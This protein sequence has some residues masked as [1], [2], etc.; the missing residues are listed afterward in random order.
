MEY[1]IRA[2]NKWLDIED[3]LLVLEVGDKK[4][5]EEIAKRHK[6]TVIGIVSRVITKIIY[7]NLKEDYNLDEISTE[8]NIDKSLLKKFIN[9]YNNSCYK[10][11]KL[12]KKFFIK[13]RGITK[14]P[15]LT[16]DNDNDKMNIILQ[17]LELL[18]N[19]ID[20]IRDIIV[21]N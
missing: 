7:P 6:R 15:K 12:L 20:M 19:K 14:K 10:D 4:S 21:D 1:Q 2:G 16:N 9:K 18:S 17:K 5:Y 8:Y 11:N 13:M 3:A